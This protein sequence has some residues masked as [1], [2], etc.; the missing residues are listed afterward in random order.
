MTRPPATPLVTAPPPTRKTEHGPGA[1]R[2]C[3]STSKEST[4]ERDERRR[5]TSRRGPRRR[6]RRD[7]RGADRVRHQ[8]L[9]GRR[10]W[11]DR[12]RADGRRRARQRGG[13][14]L[15]PGAA[16][17][18]RPR[19]PAG[20][21]RRLRAGQ[22]RLHRA[23]RRRW[24]AGLQPPG[25]RPRGGEVPPRRPAGQ[26]DPGLPGDPGR[27][28]LPPADLPLP[29]QRGPR[30]QRRRRGAHPAHPRPHRR[31]RRRGRER[32]HLYGTTDYFLQRLGLRSLDELPALAPY[33]PEV[34]VLDELAEQGRA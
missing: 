5:G 33:L 4:C 8:R 14:G 6:G 28:R 30:S 13:P 32:C 17:R 21:G 25:V 20:P 7:C 24:V 29:R 9:P 34:D 12:G 31:G 27:H 10:T 1:P 26:A 22:P 23:Q 18:G 19:P 3:R 11:C 2:R 16:G 15:G